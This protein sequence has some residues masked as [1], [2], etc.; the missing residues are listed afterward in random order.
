MQEI[1]RLRRQLAK[2]QLERAVMLGSR[3]RFD[4]AARI[5][6]QAVGLDPEVPQAHAVLA[7]IRFWSGDIDGASASIER[8]EQT[9][10]A[11][12][13][14]ET[15]RASIDA[16]RL[17]ESQRRAAAELQAEAMQQL[18][19]RLASAI[20]EA[21]DWLSAERLTMLAYIASLLLLLGIAGRR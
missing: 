10:L 20:S 14:A 12:S 9:G 1:R 2:S 13:A 16:L 15:M 4:L 17:R 8:A 3:G 5:A 6:E 19:A 21:H 11:R 18:N 7:K